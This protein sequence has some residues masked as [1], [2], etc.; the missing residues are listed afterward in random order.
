MAEQG[1]ITSLIK[2]DGSIWLFFSRPA[3][4]RLHHSVIEHAF[5]TR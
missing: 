2:S 5:S 4:F 1:F 3:R